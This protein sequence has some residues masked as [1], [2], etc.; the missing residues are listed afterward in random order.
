[1]VYHLKAVGINPNLEIVQKLLP[2]VR[3]IVTNRKKVL[4]ANELKELYLCSLDI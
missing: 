1:L 3:E 4:S 2:K